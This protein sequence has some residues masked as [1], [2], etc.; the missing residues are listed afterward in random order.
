[1]LNPHFFG[2]IVWCFLAN[3]V[4]CC[5]LRVVSSA[6]CFAL[7]LCFVNKLMLCINGSTYLT[8]LKFR[9]RQE[10]ILK[11]NPVV[12]IISFSHHYMWP[13][14]HTLKCSNGLHIRFNLYKIKTSLNCTLL[15]VLINIRFLLDAKAC[16]TGIYPKI[17]YTTPS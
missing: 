1:M 14:W 16:K 13:V 6:I 15:W 17:S 10:Q 5:N 7:I 2:H 4:F 11:D 8:Y 3:K 12:S 9:W